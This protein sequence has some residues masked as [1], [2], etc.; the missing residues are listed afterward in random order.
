[1]NPE[2]LLPSLASMLVVLSGTPLCGFAQQESPSA[3]APVA[4]ATAASVASRRE[5]TLTGD[6]PGKLVPPRISSMPRPV[7]PQSLRQASVEGTVIVQ[8]DV[9]EEGFVV[10]PKVQESAHPAFSAAALDALAKAR[11]IPALRDGKPSLYRNVAIPIVFNLTEKSSSFTDVLLS[12]SQEEIRGKPGCQP[13]DALGLSMAY[14]EATDPQLVSANGD[15]VPADAMAILLVVVN[16]RGGVDRVVVLR[17]THPALEEPTRLSI[18]AMRFKPRVVNDE[19]VTS[20]CVLLLGDVSRCYSY[21]E[22]PPIP[23]KAQ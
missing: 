22:I 14:P 1:M 20:N 2:R 5:P 16:P 7:Y 18:Q 3:S 8:F 10:S 9:D 4:T 15:P 23:S 12:Y 13:D 17:C 21:V 11:F 19:P 6:L